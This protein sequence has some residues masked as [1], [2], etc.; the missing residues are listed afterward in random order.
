M[1]EISMKP[2]EQKPGFRTEKK[3]SLAEEVREL[4]V[5]VQGLNALTKLHN[6]A[7]TT[8]AQ[9][10]NSTFKKI[11]KDM[12]GAVAMINSLQY[13]TLAMMELLQ[14]TPS[15]IDEL[16]DKMRAE[17]FDKASL[18]LDTKN[19]YVAS[20]LTDKN[21]IITITTDCKEDPDRSIFRS[22]VGLNDPDVQKD[23]VEKAI[24][25]VVGDVFEV[26][27]GEQVHEVTILAIRAE[28]KPEKE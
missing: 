13:R 24:G 3:L 14:I 10:N 26:S 18:E 15:A 22:R 27:L 8:V 19:G 7:I 25:K 11:D 5:A 23:F 12:E 4:I 17:D 21:S 6:T 20:D 28:T 1:N 9:N 16:A 2:Q